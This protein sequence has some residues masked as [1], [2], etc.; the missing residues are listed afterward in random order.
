MRKK[1]I[2]DISEHCSTLVSSC[3]GEWTWDFRVLGRKVFWV[4]YAVSLP[5]VRNLGFLESA[6]SDGC[7]MESEQ[8]RLLHWGL[9]PCLWEPQK[10]PWSQQSIKG[11]PHSTDWGVQKGEWTTDTLLRT[12]NCFLHL[13]NVPASTASLC[14]DDSAY[15]ETRKNSVWFSTFA[16][17]A[18]SPESWQQPRFQRYIHQVGEIVLLGQCTV[19]LCLGPRVNPD[20]QWIEEA[21]LLW[22]LLLSVYLKTSK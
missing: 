4:H 20:P 17:P 16:I 2:S 21:S 9:G 6:G 15:S 3:A 10:P 13:T 1:G 22:S 8:P 12:Q 18:L 14:F 11:L 7:V 5:S 19:L